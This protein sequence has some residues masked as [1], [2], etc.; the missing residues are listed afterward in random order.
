MIKIRSSFDLGMTLFGGDSIA[1]EESIHD[2][3]T[4]V[5]DD[6]CDYFSS[7]EA[8]NS[9]PA[10]GNGHNGHNGTAAATSIPELELQSHQL[11][12]KIHFLKDCS[13]ARMALDEASSCS[14][15]ATAGGTTGSSSAGTRTVVRAHWFM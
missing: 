8:V 3:L 6:L 2:T 15:L 13:R 5:E 9:Q 11:R 1:I 10:E 14:L 7:L 4:N 12:T